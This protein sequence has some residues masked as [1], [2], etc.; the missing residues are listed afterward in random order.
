MSEAREQG[1]TGRSSD[2]P[3]HV[4]GQDNGLRRAQA[5]GSLQT[6]ATNDSFGHP[7]GSN[8]VFCTTRPFDG[9]HRSAAVEHFLSTVPV[10][11]DTSTPSSANH[12]CGAVAELTHIGENSNFRVIPKGAASSGPPPSTPPLPTSAVPPMEV[13]APRQA[14]SSSAGTLLQKKPVPSLVTS[15]AYSDPQA[16]VTANVSPLTAS[17]PMVASFTSSAAQSRP[18]LPR[19]PSRRTPVA[20]FP[21]KSSVGA[22]AASSSAQPANTARPTSPSLRGVGY[23]GSNHSGHSPASEVGVG[24]GGADPGTPYHYSPVQRSPMGPWGPPASRRAHNGSG[25][26]FSSGFIPLPGGGGGG[27]PHSGSDAELRRTFGERDGVSLSPT[28]ATAAGQALRGGSPGSSDCLLPSNVAPSHSVGSRHRSVIRASES[29]FISGGLHHSGRPAPSAGSGGASSNGAFP[30]QPR[31]MN[32]AERIKELRSADD[33]SMY[34]PVLPYD[35]SKLGMQTRRLAAQ[36][37]LTAGKLRALEAQQAGASF[38]STDRGSLQQ[39]AAHSFGGGGSRAGAYP[40]RYPTSSGGMPVFMAQEEALIASARHYGSAMSEHS[41]LRRGGNVRSVAGGGPNMAGVRRAVT[42]SLSPRV[43]TCLEAVAEGGFGNTNASNASGSAP[44]RTR[45]ASGGI[46]SPVGSFDLKPG[47]IEHKLANLFQ[48]KSHQITNSNFYAMDS[49]CGVAGSSTSNGGAA[50]PPRNTD[51]RKDT[52]GAGT[53]GGGG[54]RGGG[55]GDGSGGG[56]SSSNGGPRKTVKVS[57]S[58]VERNREGKWAAE[59]KTD[60]EGDEDER[61]ER[62]FRTRN[63]DALHAIP[64]DQRRQLPMSGFGTRFFALLS[65]PRFWEKL[66]W[67]VRGSLLTVLPTMVLSL[68]PST[69]HMFPMP[70]SLA[71]NAFWITMP[72]F[73]SGLRE[74]MIAL[75]GFSVGLLFLCVIVAARPGPEWVSLLLL[76][77]FTLISSFVAEETKKTA[78]FVLASTIMQYI[79]NPTGTDYNYVLQ[80]YIGL[81]IGLAFGTAGFVV[82]FIRWSSDIARHYIKAMGSS[83]SIDLQGTLS[84]FWVRT[85]LERELNVVRL[86]QLRATADKCLGKI[87]TALNESGYEPHTGAYMMCMINR[88]NFCKSIH[89]ILGS[90]SHVIELIA[91]NPSLIDTPMCTAFGEQIGDHLAVISSAM[92]SMVLKIVDFE[93]IVTPQ[94]IQFFREAREHFQDALSRVREDVILTNENYETDESDVLLGFFMFSLDEMCEVISQFEETAHPPS[95]LWNAMLFPVR[96]VKS[97]MAAFRN[98]AFTVVRRRTIPRRLKEAIKLSLCITLPT[99]FQVYA[100]GNDAVSPAAGAAVIALIYNPT[101]S[102]SFHYASGRLLGTVLGSMGALLSVQVAECRLWVLYI[103]IT[104]L[105]FIGAYVQAAPGFYALGNAIVSSTISVC[106]Q[107][108]DQSA[109]MVRIQQ[110]CFAILMYFVIACAL[111]P[112][113]ARTKVKMSLNVTLRC[114]REAITRMLRN[115]DMPYDANEV[116]ADVSALLIEMHK[117]VQTQSRFIPGAVEEPTM[118]SVEYPEDSWKRIVEAEKKLYLALSMMRFAYNTFMSSRADVTTEL[119]VH[120]V[121]L[122]RIAPHAQDLSDLI[123]ASIDLYLLSL[124]KM[125]TVPTSHLTRLRVGM[126]NAH[127][128]IL[129]TYMATISRKVAGE[130]DTG[131]GEKGED[132][133]YGGSSYINDDEYYGHSDCGYEGAGRGGNGGSS[134]QPTTGARPYTENAD[135]SGGCGREGNGGSNASVDDKAAARAGEKVGGKQTDE[136]TAWREEDHAVP[137]Q[138]RLQRRRSGGDRAHRCGNHSCGDSSGSSCSETAERDDNADARRHKKAAKGGEGKR[139][140]GYLTYELTAEEAAA[141]RAF[142]ASRVSSAAF[143]SNK[144]M[145]FSNAT[146]S[147][148]PAGGASGASAIASA[149]R[150]SM[151]MSGSPPQCNNDARLMAISGG[152]EGLAAALRKKHKVVVKRGKDDANGGDAEDAASEESHDEGKG[153]GG[154]NDADP[155]PEIML[156]NASFLKNSSFKGASFF[157]GLFSK[158]SKEPRDLDAAEMSQL[159]PG[160]SRGSSD[161]SSAS[162]R[163]RRAAK[164]KKQRRRHRGKRRKGNSGDRGDESISECSTPLTSPTHHL[165]PS[166]VGSDFSDIEDDPRP[167]RRSH[168]STKEPRVSESVA[169]SKYGKTD[170]RPPMASSMPGALSGDSRSVANPVGDDGAVQEGAVRAEGNPPPLA[171]TTSM[172]SGRDSAAEV[173]A[174]FGKEDSAAASPQQASGLTGGQLGAAVAN[175]TVSFASGDDPAVLAASV[176]NTSS[177]ATTAA[178]YPSS[179]PGLAQCSGAEEEKKVDS[180]DDTNHTSGAEAMPDRDG[181]GTSHGSADKKPPHDRSDELPGKHG[182]APGKSGDGQGDANDDADMDKQLLDGDTTNNRHLAS[183][184]IDPSS[185][186]R[187]RSFVSGASGQRMGPMLNKARDG[188]G[189]AVNSWE[190]GEILKNLSF[191]DADKGVFVLTNHDIHSLEAFLFGTRALI[192][193]INDLQKA[194]LE[195]DHATDLAKQ[196]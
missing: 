66:D 51:G 17:V 87:E 109:A 10:A 56:S 125:T 77:C 23:Q 18:P 71:F 5:T 47:L 110:N 46:S 70:S 153:K 143:T 120:W 173:S 127:Q 73:G 130:Q 12:D 25:G 160:R 74:L 68:E 140:M 55:G 79:V 105:S 161:S 38:G 195:M 134:L 196:L 156:S 187:R 30:A 168:S 26:Q 29:S 44:F 171:R 2:D 16:A 169:G 166:S 92:D 115:L 149:A 114:M 36:G 104:V 15:A 69:S 138:Q 159:R 61:D 40:S 6:S 190:N 122:H 84:S 183:F 163:S 117:K 59:K 88:F 106:T 101:G 8:P 72:T 181:E 14:A 141:L 118:G 9:E 13:P 35:Q 86:R 21:S 123:Y 4:L 124:S 62:N 180:R 58:D 90:M 116:T 139:R 41:G 96:D 179:P 186:M 3:N 146:F 102:E 52:A 98:L 54:G 174:V 129:D 80:Y 97:V 177:A 1:D 142:L 49:G 121:V 191:F 57:R 91:D 135:G 7:G 184:A 64:W 158:R 145:V 99:I 39:P 147:G 188:D 100:L 182:G 60:T 150:A 95:T 63:I 164:K 162:S 67:T 151:A 34:D 45:N 133:M 85:P 103:F 11:S 192:V 82:P 53:G 107:Y 32:A 50:V 31:W 194:L 148:R 178:H 108:K 113:H 193:Y 43:I 132:D 136:A 19:S 24:G 157:G 20:A 152:D 83:L 137:P 176:N 81:L 33:V 185:G 78:A 42:A 76:F 144:S 28:S 27:L 94:E 172:I 165:R 131:A 112:M 22:S 154:R 167:R 128:A 189:T 65:T 37:V 93:R 170:G 155:V 119:S 75:K 126:V 111:W 175:S 48:G 89:N